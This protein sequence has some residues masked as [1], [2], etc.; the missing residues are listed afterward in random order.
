MKGLVFLILFGASSLTFADSATLP[1]G[2][3]GTE[4]TRSWLDRDP[5][6]VEA[7]SQLAAAKS[8]A[9]MLSASAN[10]W[11]LGYSSQRRDYGSGPK[12]TE[13]TL[14]IERTFR[15]PGKGVLDRRL[16]SAGVAIADAKRQD[17]YRLAARDLA[18]LL[19]DWQASV[20]LRELLVEQM[21]IAEKNLSAVDRRRRAGDAAMMEMNAAEADTAETRRRLSQATSEEQLA[22]LNLQMRFPQAVDIAPRLGEP[23]GSMEP[24]ER[25][26]ERVLAASD[27]MR[28]AGFEVERAELSTRRARADWLP[29]PTFGAFKSNEAFSTERIVGASISI[30]IPGRY[31][32]HRVSQAVNE[33]DAARA[34]RDVQEQVVS[35][36]VARNYIEATGGEQRWRLAEESAKKTKDN[37]DLSQRAYSLGEVDLQ[38]LLL[39]RRQSSLAA[40]SAL[41]AQ[42]SAVRA[43]CR[44]LIDA[45][46][47]W[48]PN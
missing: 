5:R 21:A 27:P 8:A 42:V 25:W 39:S 46:L 3:P 12:S 9:G 37:A 32:G 40:E 2:F 45:H 20:R 41:Q 4:V 36:E 43:Y 19:I 38:S 13:P 22:R 30:P 15:F 10:E 18:D 14:E 24:L 31:R 28:I 48:F 34:V 23:N 6:V 16:G 44:L 26:Q 1:S 35:A 11:T 47:M 17:A 7:T 33:A 29:D